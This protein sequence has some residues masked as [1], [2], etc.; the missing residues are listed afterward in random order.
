MSSTLT[1]FQMMKIR[2]PGDLIW[3]SFCLSLALHSIATSTT[4]SNGM[5]LFNLTIIKPA[6]LI[7]N[8]FS[9]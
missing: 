5:E 3:F 9:D 8:S 2:L 1:I 4:I 7:T 6:K